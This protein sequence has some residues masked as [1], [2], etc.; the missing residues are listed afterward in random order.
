MYD[1]GVM[2]YVV[3]ERVVDWDVETASPKV[4]GLCTTDDVVVKAS[5]VRKGLVGCGQNRLYSDTGAGGLATVGESLDSD[6]LAVE[7]AKVG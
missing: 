6:D 4:I 3:T 2:W 5:Q 7:V 1:P